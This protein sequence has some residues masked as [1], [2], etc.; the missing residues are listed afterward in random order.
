MTVQTVTVDGGDRPARTD[1]GKGISY[2]NSRHDKT[3]CQNNNNN[4]RINQMIA[5]NARMWM[6]QTIDIDLDIN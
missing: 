2:N 5:R 6:V 1:L 4:G 3:N